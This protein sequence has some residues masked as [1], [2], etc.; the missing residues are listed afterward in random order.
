[1]RPH[2]HR[3]EETGILAGHTKRGR[4]YLPP[5]R[6]LGVKTVDWVRDDLPDLLWPVLLLAEQGPKGIRGVIEWQKNVTSQLADGYQFEDQSRLSGRLTMIDAC[7]SG[8][9]HRTAL[10]RATAL[11]G[12]LLSA[13]V[14]AALSLYPARPASWFVGEVSEEVEV[15]R[16]LNLIARG[17]LDALSNGHHEALLKFLSITCGVLDGSFTSTA[18]TIDLL[19]D[20]PANQA[21]R[22]QADTVIRA[23]YSASKGALQVRNPEFWRSSLDWAEIFWNA[24][25][26]LTRCLPQ[27]EFP[28][29]ADVRGEDRD[30][31]MDSETDEALA[32]AALEMDESG[33][34]VDNPRDER[35]EAVEYANEVARLFGLYAAALEAKV[36]LDIFRPAKN[37]VHAGLITRAAQ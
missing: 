5:M 25:G 22:S 31:S 1:L 10:L 20:Y 30:D 21:K 35:R 17:V 28:D 3:P 2:Q 23:F 18:E 24:N 4:S 13:E 14:S 26:R 6:E 12:G 15:D 36:P 34:A 11:D 27:S 16:A 33:L 37:E 32:S 19:K 8:S 9:E 7:A 29:S